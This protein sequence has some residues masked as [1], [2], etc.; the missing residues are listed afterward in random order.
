MRSISA[1]LSALL[2]VGFLSTNAPAYATDSS[3]G[4]RVTTASGSAIAGAQ[5]RAVNGASTVATATTAGDGSYGLTMPAGTYAIEVTPAS[6]TLTPASAIWVEAPRT[7][8]LDFILTEPN[9][10]RVR[11]TASINL[12]S[13]EPLGGGNLLFAGAGNRVG[14]DGY[15]SMLQPAGGSGG[16]MLSGVSASI[17]SQSLVVSASGGP[18]A[19]LLQDTDIDFTIPVTRTTVIVRGAD[20]APLANAPVLLNSGGWGKPAGSVEIFQG[21]TAFRASWTASA[22]TDATGTVT[23]VRPVLTS[24]SP[25]TL[26]IEGPTAAWAGSFTDVTIPATGG[27]FSQALQLRSAPSPSATPTASPS[28]SPSPSPTSTPSPVRYAATGTI[29]YSSGGPVVGAVIMPVDP[30]SRVNGGNSS[31]ANGAFRIVQ[32]AG[33]TGHWSIASR[34]Q[35]GLAVRDPMTFYLAGGATRT[36][37]SDQSVNFSLPT[38]LYRIRVVDPAGTPI[39]NARVAVGVLDAAGNEVRVALIPGEPDFRGRWGGWDVTGPDGYAQVP[40]L[41][42]TTEVQTQVTVDAD[43]NSR[44][45]SQSLTRSSSG[46]SETVIV[47]QGRQPVISALSRT[48][49]SPGDTITLS[50]Q[51]LVGIQR[52]LI[53]SV[54]QEFTVDSA[55]QMRIR[56]TSNSST[57]NLRLEGLNTAVNGERVTITS[58]NL[59]VSQPVLP[60]GMV[61]TSYRTQLTVEGGLA[62]YRWATVAGSLPTG[63]RLSPDGVISGTPTRALASQVT[64]AVTDTR[65]TTASRVISWTI[66]P[67]PATAPGHVSRL[68]AT[69]GAERVSLAWNLPGSDGGNAITGYQVQ[70]STNGNTWTTEI[71]TTGTIS[72]AVSLPAPAGIPRWYRVAAVNAS[73]VGGFS[74]GS[75]SGP[76]TAFTV[77]TAPTNLQVIRTTATKLRVSWN[78]P[79]SNNGAAVTAYRIRTSTDGNTWTTAVASTGQLSATLN[80]PRSAG[81]W[82]Q[83]SA[84][85]LAG[86]GTWA[87]TP[88]AN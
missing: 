70:S 79:S 57:G 88:A 34:P 14:S 62:P 23:L 77:P 38:T 21:L 75:V 69:A 8:S 39:P 67:R 48:T 58:A 9:P 24:A 68:R 16:W 28:A 15:V 6:A 72:L 81:I 11:V 18:T 43:P 87:T 13:G 22:R 5:V 41:D 76:V 56:V 27:D 50:G 44:F 26:N 54:P 25:G 19:T 29:T 33:F 20:G 49:A 17:G 85:N 65:G 73:G 46:L 78:P 4:G 1:A 36:W 82:V 61:G 80:V 64:L 35:A 52:V 2:A 12:D 31:D 84:Q 7:T 74:A 63:L 59:Q 86:L 40:G 10:G 30:T 47:L 66:D 42:T 55:T 83:V 51:D 45:V 60:T 53:G 3:I 37:T 32:P 71:A